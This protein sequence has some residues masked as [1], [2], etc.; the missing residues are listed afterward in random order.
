LQ[1]LNCDDAYLFDKSRS[2]THQ[3]SPAS[4]NST[5]QPQPIENKD[6]EPTTHYNFAAIAHYS[7]DSSNGSGN[8]DVVS[9]LLTKASVLKQQKLDVPYQEQC[10]QQQEQWKADM[11]QGL[12]DLMKVIQSKKT[13]FI[14]GAQG[15]QMHHAQMMQSHL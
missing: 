11:Q 4:S 6:R 2:I 13:Q 14:G 12:V 3:D 9:D 10:M 5:A 7:S 1:S 8:D 15:L